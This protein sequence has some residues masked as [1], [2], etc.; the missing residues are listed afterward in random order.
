MGTNYYM[1]TKNKDLAHEYFA[2][3]CDYGGKYPEYLN[4]EYELYD[5]PDFY[6]QIHLNKLSCGWKPLFQNHKAFR[7]FNE[8]EKFYKEHM[9]DITFEDEYGE[10]YTFEEY[11]QEVIEHSE[12]TPEPVKW[13]YK[14]DEI[15]GRLGHKYLMTER[16]DPE[17]AD[18]W[19]PF[20]HIDYSRTER[21]AKD[22][23]K[24][25]GAYVS[26]MS[27][28]KYHRDP[29]YKFDWVEGEFC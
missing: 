8:L 28:E 2:E 21:E 1:I 15:C 16:C 27:E 7:T 20:D 11:K 3:R 29:D 6:Y 9:N 26:W 23:L 19:V 4:Q 12:R 5:V 17:E 24:A 25:Y 22:K 14:E 18:L 13:V 10:S